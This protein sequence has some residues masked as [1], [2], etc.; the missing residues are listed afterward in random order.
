MSSSSVAQDPA[1]R[2]TTVL[3]L[4]SYFKGLKALAEAARKASNDQGFAPPHQLALLSA[5]RMF[6]SLVVENLNR[7]RITASDFSDYLQIRTKHIA[8]VQ[9]EYAGFGE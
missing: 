4:A 2:P 3:C 9:Q 1:K 8:E 5:G 6:V 7:D